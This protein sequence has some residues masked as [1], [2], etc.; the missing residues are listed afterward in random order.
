MNKI[1]N[2]LEYVK[3]DFEPI[4][5]FYLKDTLNKK[6]W[7]DFEID[8]DVREKLI[9]IAEDFYDNTKLSANIKD[10]VLIGSL[11]NYNWSDKYS[12]YDVHIIV[13]FKDINN[14]T[15]LVEEYVD[16]SKK[17]WNNNND[18]YI[19]GFEVELA[20]QDIDDFNQSKDSDRMGGVFSLSNN[21]WLK[22]PEKTDYVPN[23]KLIKEK[24][25]TLMGHIDD[26]E[27]AFK[28]KN[29]LS[30][31]RLKTVWKKIKKTRKM[32]LE[33][34]GEFS[35]GNMVF[36]L[37]RRNGYIKKIMDLKKEIYKRQFEN[38]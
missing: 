10:I 33:E 25:K 27:D 36:K 34:G 30:Q 28:N 24:A 2:L 20:I 16:L 11:C 32:G 8:D 18:I 17:L 37:L 14:D 22:R 21:K 13:D 31:K 5:S 29:L 38:G 12:D 26:L 19:K 4:K 35:V 7:C 23:E 9:V 3:G 15:D 1:K 6:I